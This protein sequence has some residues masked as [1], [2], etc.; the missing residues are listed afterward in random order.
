MPEPGGLSPRPAAGRKPGAEA[1]LP[2][3]C[4]PHLDRGK[5]SQR[6]LCAGPLLAAGLRGVP[7]GVPACCS[8]AG[9]GRE[10]GLERRWGGESDSGRGRESQVCRT[11]QGGAGRG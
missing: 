2:P 6:V 1:G 3:V 10:V 5:E 7:R 9:P 4:A 8:T 11:C